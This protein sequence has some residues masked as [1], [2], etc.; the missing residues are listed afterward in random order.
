[1]LAEQGASSPLPVVAVACSE[2]LVSELLCTS[3]GT[4]TSDA[5]ALQPGAD[6][7]HQQ[8]LCCAEHAWLERSCGVAVKVPSARKPAAWCCTLSRSAAS[9]M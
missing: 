3:Q 4:W 2:Q 1:M 8:T 5:L 9:M 7:Q 6:Q